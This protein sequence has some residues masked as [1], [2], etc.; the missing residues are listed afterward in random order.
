MIDQRRLRPAAA[1]PP[2]DAQVDGRTVQLPTVST[3]VAP[4]GFSSVPVEARPLVVV[5]TSTDVSVD[6]GGC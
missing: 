6:E 3:P 2:S 5:R 1:C 4:G